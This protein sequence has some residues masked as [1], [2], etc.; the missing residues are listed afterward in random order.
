MK[1]VQ[2]SLE[3]AFLVEMEPLRDERGCFMRTFCRREFEHRGLESDFVQHS[4][5]RSNRR[6]TLRGMHFQRLPH[7]EVKIVR[8]L[9]GVIWDVLLDLRADSP[10]F[11]KWQGFELHGESATELYVPKGFAHGF[12]ALT[13]DVEVS[14]LIST[15]YAPGF[16][17]GVRFDDR[18][19]GITW[20]I[21][22]T[23]ISDKDRAWPD[24]GRDGGC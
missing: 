1:F 3:G 2:T 15:E 16:A 12:Q 13:D 4:M 22:V 14:Y 7:E 19:F 23:T 10:T 20:P 21:P 5:S 18:K 8:C 17:E 6:G 11:A 9:R 24:F